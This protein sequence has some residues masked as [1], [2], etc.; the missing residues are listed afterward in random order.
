MNNLKKRKFETETITEYKVM[1]IFKAANGASVTE[2]Y[3]QDKV[4]IEGVCKKKTEIQG[5]EIVSAEVNVY[6]RIR[7]Y[8]FNNDI[9]YRSDVLAYQ[10]DVNYNEHR[11]KKERN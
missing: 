1:V 2:V 10:V 4:D 6:L 8:N 5:I 11:Q 3:T 7:V 9:I